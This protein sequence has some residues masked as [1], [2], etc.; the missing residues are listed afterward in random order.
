[1][2]FKGSRQILQGDEMKFVNKIFIEI[3]LKTS[4]MFALSHD[5]ITAELS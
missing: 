1:M 5:I 3:S 2:E 4:L